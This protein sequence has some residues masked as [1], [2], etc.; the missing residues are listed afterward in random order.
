MRS[1]GRS[2]SAVLKPQ[3]Y[4]SLAHSYIYPQWS[5]FFLNRYVMGRGEYPYVCRVRT[6]LGPVE[7]TL[8][9]HEDCFT[10]QEIFGLECYKANDA[11]VVVDF[12]ANIGVSAAYFLTRNKNAHVYG[13]EPLP[14]N[15]QRLRRNLAPFQGRCTLT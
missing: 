14:Q 6:P 13:F 11:E 2:L 3:H 9:Q 5:D 7:L 15:I 4:V 10:I 12:G 8:Y 1:I